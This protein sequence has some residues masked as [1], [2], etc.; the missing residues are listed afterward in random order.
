MAGRLD[1]KAVLEQ[2]CQGAAQFV[3]EVVGAG[4]VP[5]A[6][7]DGCEEMLSEVLD[8]SAGGALGAMLQVEVDRVLKAGP[9]LPMSVGAGLPRHSGVAKDEPVVPFP[10]YLPSGSPAA[11][12]WHKQAYHARAGRVLWRLLGDAMAD[13][14]L[15]GM[16]HETAIA[17][18]ATY[19]WGC[20]AMCSG[21]NMTGNIQRLAGALVAYM[22]FD[23]IGDSLQDAGERRLVLKEMMQF[24]ATGKWS[25]WP[26]E[27]VR[28]MLPPETRKACR[29]SREWVGHDRGAAA[30]RAER[31]IGQIAMAIAKERTTEGHGAAAN[32]TCDA[33]DGVVLER[34]LR[35]NVAAVAF[36]LFAFLDRPQDF[37]GPLLHVAG[38][39]AAFAQLYDDLLDRDEDMV[40]NQRTAIT[41]LTDEAYWKLARAAA[42]R[43]PRLLDD[44]VATSTSAH[45]VIQAVSMERIAQWTQT[46]ALAIHLMVAH[47]NREAFAHDPIPPRVLRGLSPFVVLRPLRDWLQPGVQPPAEK[48]TGDDQDE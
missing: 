1:A 28:R 16:R 12:E 15:D 36:L 11:D 10:D 35:K 20:I 2:L 17:N 5:Q 25:K 47:R 24:W 30:G 37:K 44:V 18:A 14:P 22:L 3:S 48:I 34:S 6:W 27:V 31:D 19:G 23:H 33:V 8:W 4:D 41:A 7:P 29:I 42:S 40:Q 39:A 38:R 46:G 9:E 21:I 45:L 26:N 13:V 32:R 43:V